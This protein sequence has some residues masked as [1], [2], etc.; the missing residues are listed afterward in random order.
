MLLYFILFHPVLTLAIFPIYWLGNF[1]LATKYNLKF[2]FL[3]IYFA[4]FTFTILGMPLTFLF[5]SFPFVWL[6][7][8]LVAVS[9]LLLLV[10]GGFASIIYTSK[11]SIKIQK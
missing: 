10:G 7:T 3:L 11:I 4:G 8:L 1:I 9:Y 2:D 6:Q 5:L